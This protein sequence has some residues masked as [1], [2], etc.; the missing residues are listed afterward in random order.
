MAI[1][2]Y[3]PVHH[4]MFKLKDVQTLQNHALRCH[5]VSDPRDESVIYLHS[6]SNV[7]MVNTRRKRQILTCIWRNIENGV[8]ETSNPVRHTRANIAPTIYLPVPRQTLFKKS[9][10]YYGATLWNQLPANIRLLQT[11]EGFK[12]ELYKHI[13]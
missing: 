13:I 3:H 8:I 10:F 4:K 12:S 11:L 9:V 5:Q 1:Y 2:F 7:I 6:V